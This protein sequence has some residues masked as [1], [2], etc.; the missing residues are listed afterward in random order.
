MGAPVVDVAVLAGHVETQHVA[1]NQRAKL[2]GLAVT[3]T[4]QQ[5]S[6]KNN[7]IYMKINKY[8]HIYLSYLYV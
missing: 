2:H 5:K 8:I 4:K 6:N 3:Q 7:R 1:Q